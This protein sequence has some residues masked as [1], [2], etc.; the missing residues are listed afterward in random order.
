MSW[1]CG[2]RWFNVTSHIKPQSNILAYKN[3][4]FYWF[5]SG[6][7]GK[8]V[9]IKGFSLIEV[10]VVMTMITLLAGVG[11]VMNLDDFRSYL[12]RDE[13]NVLVTVLQKARSQAVNNVCIGSGCT[14]GLPHGVHLAPGKYTIFQGSSFNPDASTNQDIDGNA[15]MS[16]AYTTPDIL[17]GQLSGQVATDWDVVLD[18]AYGHTTA[19]SVN[20]EG[21]NRLLGINVKFL[22]SK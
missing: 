4:L 2:T 1:S 16:L 13:R 8:P 18:D 17:F 12:F 21:E 11:L 9:L 7:L 14:D 20:K 15:N 10:M 19:V 6:V 3:S 5:S 22:I